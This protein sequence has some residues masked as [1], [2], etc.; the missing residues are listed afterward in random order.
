[1]YA[2]LDSDND[3]LAKSNDDK[4]LAF[5]QNI[6]PS[7]TTKITGAPDELQIKSE[8][9][10]TYHRKIS[11][12]GTVITDYESLDNS[13]YIAN[14]DTLL[15]SKTQV[16]DTLSKVIG[17][18]LTMQVLQNRREIFNDEDNPL[19]LENHI[20]LIGPTGSV[21]N[22]NN[23]HGKGGWHNQQVQ[24]NRY[25][26]PK[27]LLIYYGWLSGFNAYWDN[28][29]VAQDM[30]RY[31][32]LVFGDGIQDP[33]HGDY[34]NTQIIIA[35]IKALN[36]SALI[37]GY[38][39]TNQDYASFQTKTDQ[40]E[41]LQ[42]HGIFMDESG[43]DYGKTRSEFNTRVDYVHGKT[44]AKLAFANAWNTDNI[45][46]TANDSSFPNTTYNSDLLE[47]SLTSDDWIL[48]ESLGVNTA[49]YSGNAGY[50]SGP[51]WAIRISKAITLRATY[52][53]N[54]AGCGIINDDN[55][56]GQDLFDFG[57]ISALMVALESFGTSDTSYGSS[58][59]KAKY[60]TRPTVNELV[61]IYTMNPT[62]QVDV[63]DSDVYHRF[64]RG[65]HAK[66]DF[67][68]S[69]QDSDLIIE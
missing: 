8:Y 43:Y 14:I 22:L 49:A 36:P 18:Y 55:A 56:N 24:S 68:S 4:S 48:L 50:E 20:P 60:W 58:S 38:A 29:L 1:M 69:A 12:D 65:G 39:S 15:T 10:P 67:S 16:I 62:I 42:V 35:R 21:T 11:G 41:T 63:N 6:I 64:L 34:A 17:P 27:N 45:L 37:F 19:Y 40:W 52:L 61:D 31:Q 26:R 7:V 2:F 44:Y 57:F 46:G 54:F 5:V 28:E 3:V 13:D 51:Q 25:L 32:V 53:V 9:T 47:S 23:I 66:L 30:A 33:T 59:G